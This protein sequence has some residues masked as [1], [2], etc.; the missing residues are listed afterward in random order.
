MRDMFDY[1]EK[2]PGLCLDILKDRDK[3]IEKLANLY[4]KKERKK[5]VV[6]ASGSSYNIAMSVKWY[7]QNTLNV[8][9]K[10]VWSVT[11]VMYDYAYDDQAFVICMSQSGRSTNTIAAVK[12]AMSLGHEVCVLTTNKDAPI[13]KYCSNVFEYGSGSDDYY[14]AKG[15][16]CSSVFL[17]KFTVECA[18]KLQQWKEQKKKQEIG[19]IE[20]QISCMADSKDKSIKFFESH[21]TSILNSRRMMLVGIGSTF[22]VALEGALK[23]NEMIG[24]ATNAYEMEEFV[25]GPSYEIRKDHVIIFIDN[26]SESHDRMIQLF[27]AT[28]GLTDHVYL[29]TNDCSL[30]DKNTLNITGGDNYDMNI[31]NDII[32]FQVFSECICS[33]LDLL[34]YNLSNYDFERKIKAKA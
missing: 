1:M 27:N 32:P 21:K 5:I 18:S 7:M 28:K 8:E 20:K 16:P 23:L 17:M 22:G 25:H 34:S 12:K 33:E 13:Q 2:A 10:V 6:V 30:Q 19:K 31:I 26:N 9:V 15:Y 24:S 4:T 29:I 3:R 14:V 11:Y